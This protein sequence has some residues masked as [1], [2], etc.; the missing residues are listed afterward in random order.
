MSSEFADTSGGGPMRPP[1]PSDRPG[2]WVAVVLLCAAVCAAYWNSLDAAFVFDD[3]HAI[4]ENPHLLRVW[5]LAESMSAPPQSS[6]SGRPIVALTFAMD[7]AVTGPSPRSY[8]AGNIL[9]HLLAALL[10]FGIVRRT[11]LRMAD[12]GAPNDAAQAGTAPPM[13]VSTLR[14]F[15]VSAL[16]H[17]ATW[18]AF[19]A[20]LLWAVHPLQTESV[21]YIVQRTESLMGMFYLATLY[22]FVRSLAGRRRVMWQAASILCCALGMGCKEVM[23]TAPLAVYGYDSA[24]V[25]RSWRRPLRERWLYYTGLACTWLILASLTI[26]G[27]RS[28]SAGFGVENMTPL[29]Y[30]LSQTQVLLHY[31]RLALW[32]AALCLD[33]GWR[34]AK[35][36]G[37]VW[38]HALV[39]LG[40]LGLVV[41]AILRK[42]ALGFVGGVFFLVLAPTSSIVPIRD[43]AFEHRM[44]LSLASLF[45]LL[46]LGLHAGVGWAARRFGWSDAA[47]R[48]TILAVVAILAAGLGA[49]TAL[50]NRDYATA[51]TM[52]RDVIA[53][54]PNNPRAYANLG[55]CFLREGAYDNAVEQLAIA[56]KIYPE[57]SEALATMALAHLKAGRLAEAEPHAEAAVRSDTTSWPAHNVLGILR[58][59]QGR[60][61]EAEALFQQAIRLNPDATD[62]HFNLACL[63]EK[64]KEGNRAAAMYLQAIRL[65]PDHRMAHFNLAELLSRKGYAADALPHYDAVVRLKPDWPRGHNGRGN[66]LA[67][68]DRLDEAA[69]AY[70]EA[71]R[72]DPSLAVVHLNLGN[73]CFRA[74]Q[75]DA[76]LHEYEVAKELD[77]NLPTLQERIEAVTTTRAA[78]S[79]PS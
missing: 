27:P 48:G 70:R 60:G 68:L 40:L 8:R 20:A 4:A 41:F 16:H 31:L 34:L 30:A 12:R 19:G 2:V 69:A 7:R 13:S 37:D 51:E 54:A 3:V 35:G 15:D 71:L 28:Y 11:L 21:T 1:S 66:A 53:K 52:W 42:P 23:A 14:L 36:P 22:C 38:L 73:V 39:L 58:V 17:S 5:P 10:L 50:R 61:K 32:P 44:Y 72:L 65:D 62:P 74:G 67:R 25:C 45:V 47:R 78:T 56:L 77:S 29:T 63:L 33:Y 43:L 26:S 24:I 76:A 6:L 79:R 55:S 49:R 57:Y 64:N 59:R 75:L 46:M 9:I 18:L